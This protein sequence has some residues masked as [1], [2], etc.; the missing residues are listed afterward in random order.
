MIEGLEGLV[1]LDQLNLSKNK[2]EKV[3]NLKGL[4]KLNKLELTNNRITSEANIQ[5]LKEC[6]ELNDLTLNGNPM[7]NNYWKFCEQNLK[8]LKTLDGKT[9]QDFNKFNGEEED[10]DDHERNNFDEDM[11][12]PGL[13]KVISKEWEKELKRLK[14]KGLNGYRKRKEA[15]HESL[16]Q[17]GHAEIEGSQRLFIFGNALEVLEKEDF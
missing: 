1:N 11:S 7:G 17:S 9:P 6:T 4:T 8:H 5:E 3:Q 15:K 13:V 12:S 2:I 10:K 14:E 16:V